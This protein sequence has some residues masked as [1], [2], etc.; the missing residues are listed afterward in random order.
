MLLGAFYIRQMANQVTIQ[1]I[2]VD[3]SEIVKLL[4]LTAENCRTY[5]HGDVDALTAEYVAVH[6]RSPALGLRG[7]GCA[8]WQPKARQIVCSV[9]LY[10]LPCIAAISAR[11]RAISRSAL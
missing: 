5:D 7:K 3:A 9:G 1:L 2:N 4:A 11:N 6:D 10:R 8:C